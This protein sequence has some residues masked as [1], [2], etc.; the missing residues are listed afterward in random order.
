MVKVKAIACALK[1]HYGIVTYGRS[2]NLDLPP[3]AMY[4]RDSEYLRDLIREIE[5]LK[6]R[7]RK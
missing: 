6:E 5:R 7:L 1:R 2:E 4:K 3:Y